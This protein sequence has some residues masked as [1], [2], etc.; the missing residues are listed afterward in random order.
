M[1]G[2]DRMGK[3]MEV[4][5]KEGK[6]VCDTCPTK[7]LVHLI[8]SRGA[9]CTYLTRRRS[10]SQSQQLQTLEASLHY[11]SFSYGNDRTPNPA[12]MLGIAGEGSAEHF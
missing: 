3:R 5:K 10:R 2:R 8:C 7:R 6:G 12:A 11:F 9:L 4:E 1:E